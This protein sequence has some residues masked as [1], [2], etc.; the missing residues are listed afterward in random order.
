MFLTK[1]LT[2]DYCHQPFWKEKFVAG[3]F[4][5]FTKKVRIKLREQNNNKILYDKLIYR[6]LINVINT[7]GLNLYNDLRIKQ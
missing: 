3:L 4:S 2:K 7:E 5:I 6:D 1:V